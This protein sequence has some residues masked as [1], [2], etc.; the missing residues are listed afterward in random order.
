MLN[1]YQGDPRVTEVP[2]GYDLADPE[3]RSGTWRI[4]PEGD[5][6]SA[7]MYDA[8]DKMVDAFMGEGTALLAFA[9]ADDAIQ[10]V[11]RWAEQVAYL[12]GD[13]RNQ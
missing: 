6:W 9:T 10:M 8:D 4:R 3:G 13:A 1:R 2:H 11:L 7:A 5:G 12:F